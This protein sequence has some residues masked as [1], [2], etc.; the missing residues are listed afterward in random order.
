MNHTLSMDSETGQ[1]IDT[2]ETEVETVH[3]A[4]DHDEGTSTA[5]SVPRNTKQRKK[6]KYPTK[7][8]SS[9]FF[10]SYTEKIE[11]RKSSGKTYKEQFGDTEQFEKKRDFMI[12]L[13]KDLFHYG[14][15]VHRL[16]YLL[17]NVGESIGLPCSFFTLPNYMM[18]SIKYKDD[19]KTYLLK[20]DQHFHM[21]K[22]SM[23]N[24][25]CHELLNGR[26]TIEES[27]K[28][29]TKIKNKPSISKWYLLFLYPATS[30]ILCLIG[31][32]GS[33]EDAIISAL[34]GIFIGW[35]Q[36]LAF[37]FPITFGYL[38]EF[39]SAL[40]SAIVANIIHN[41][42]KKQGICVDTQKIVLG[43]LS[44]LLP[45]FMIGSDTIRLASSLFTALLLGF[46]LTFGDY[47]VAPNSPADCP[48]QTGIEWPWMSLLVPLAAFLI[49][50]LVEARRS[51]WVVMTF[52]SSVGFL[53]NSVLSNSGVFGNNVGATSVIATFTIGIISN[54]YARFTRDI[55]IAPILCGIILLVP[56]N[57]GVRSSL[58]FLRFKDQGE[59]L[60]SLMLQI[61]L[62]ITVG[63]FLST[64][65]V[66]PI[67]LKGPN[68][69]TRF[70]I[71]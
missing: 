20:Q 11:R 57:L 67:K 25:L 62:S 14:V 58:E 9:S 63:M 17:E 47:I 36:V 70:M 65:L 46:G 34:I 21:G 5:L 12:L 23:L 3:I 39:I 53:V 4:I 71:Y 44:M 50:V 51:Q 68:S 41:F 48:N 10:K 54:L 49:C 30:F 55:S 45:V 66:W 29:L 43:S 7:F 69:T 35:F 27:I 15:P 32:N 56:D 38:F 13:A 42:V 61:S 60:A 37:F 1:S 18:I 19:F 26:K 28:E 8:N 59:P 40:L 2:I 31:L 33:I 24:D 16:E 64:L 52:V 6:K 22:L